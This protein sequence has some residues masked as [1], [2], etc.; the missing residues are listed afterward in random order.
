[1]R[2]RISFV[3]ALWHLCRPLVATAPPNLWANP[4]RPGRYEPRILKRRPPEHSPI[5]QPRAKLRQG[6]RRP[7]DAAQV[8]AIRDYPT[9][10][11][12]LS[13]VL[14]VLRRGASA[15]TGS[16]ARRLPAR[17]GRMEF[18]IRTSCPRWPPA[19]LPHIVRV[20]RASQQ[21]LG[22]SVA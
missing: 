19:A 16:I 7:K 4:L 5:T 13:G 9:L 11:A 14:D 6:L 15:P 1:M 18:S 17:M 8:N 22:R 12:T 10:S 21:F 20:G 3:D 2:E